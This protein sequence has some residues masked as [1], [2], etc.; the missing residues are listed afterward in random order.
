MLKNNFMQVSYFNDSFNFLNRLNSRKSFCEIQRDGKVKRTGLN[1][2]YSDCYYR[3]GFWKDWYFFQPC[4]NP[5][6][7]IFRSKLIK[8]NPIREELKKKL[9]SQCS[10]VQVFKV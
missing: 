8:R 6:L 4:N 2:R 9:C 5:D 1:I 7:S 10:S 3:M